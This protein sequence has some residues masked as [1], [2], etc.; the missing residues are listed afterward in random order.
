VWALP[1]GRLVLA[2]EPL[3]EVTAPITE[4]QLVETALLNLSASRPRWLQGG[5]LGVRLDSGDLGALA[6]QTQR[7]LDA[8]GL[9]QVRIVASGGLDEFSIAELVAYGGRPVMKLSPGKGYPPGAKQVF[10]GPAGGGDLV[11]RP[12]GGTGPGGPGAA[13]GAGHG[14]RSKGRAATRAGRGP[15]ALR[16]RPGLAASAE[17]ARM[18][19]LEPFLKRKPAA[20]SGGQRQ[21][22]AMGRAIVRNPQAYLMDEPLSTLDAKLRV[23]MRAQLAAL[24]E[25]LGVTTIYVTHDQIEAMTLGTRM[26]VL[27]D[28]E[29]MQ[30]TPQSLFDAPANLFGA[31][32]IGNPA[33]NVRS[34]AGPGS[35]AGAGVRRPQDPHSRECGRRPSRPR[36]LLRQAVDHRRPSVFIGGCRAGLGQRAAAHQGRGGR[37]RGAGRLGG[38]RDLP[39]RHCPGAP[40]HHDR[41]VRQ[42]GQGPC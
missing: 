8:A 6:V 15:R 18:L 39:G 32:F 31:T 25:R 26:A 9:P 12:A 40:R 14:R 19:A 3:L 1:E 7:R 27:K 34:Q 5:P 21:R 36:P 24:H 35:G 10:R 23:S 4:A 42:S 16:G 29:L 38:Q 13:A 11:G 41:Q 28:G 30:V 37:D 22:V 20:L 2:G 17:A 33:M